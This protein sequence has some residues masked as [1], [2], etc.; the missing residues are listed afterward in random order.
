M[1]VHW[2]EWSALTALVGAV[3]VAVYAVMARTTRTGSG[4]EA[5]GDRSPI[6]SDGRNGECVA[7]TRGGAW[8]VACAATRGH[9]SCCGAGGYGGAGTGFSGSRDSCGADGGGGDVFGEKGAHSL[10]AIA[11]SWA[12]WRRNMG[13]ARSRV[14]ADLAQSALKRIDAATG[15]ERKRAAR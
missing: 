4:R 6:E 11:A 1:K 3:G 5:T 2:T 8:R 10:G 13:T 12:E 15:F 14:C 7:G 9:S